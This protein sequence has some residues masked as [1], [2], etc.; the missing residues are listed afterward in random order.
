MKTDE[1][2]RKMYG[3]ELADLVESLKNKPTRIEWKPKPK[4]LPPPP[5]QL[6]QTGPNWWDK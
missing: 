4:E 3:D 1:I 2:F 6:V 5:G